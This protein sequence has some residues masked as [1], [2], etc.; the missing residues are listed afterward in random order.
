[1]DVQAGSGSHSR[2][3]VPSSSCAE[4]YS[5]IAVIVHCQLFPSPWTP[6]KVAYIF[7]RYYPLAFAPFHLWD[8][9]GDHDQHVCELYYHAVYACMIPTV[10]PFPLPIYI[11]SRFN[12]RWSQPI[13]STTY[14]TCFTRGS[15]TFILSHPDLAY[16]CVFWAEK[17]DS[18]RSF[19]YILPLCRCS[20]LG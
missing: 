10:C 3:H 17:D 19:S 1:M 18:C 13:V 20:Y 9:L 6:V 12:Y 7:C 16:I 4:R 2:K 15:F 14:S 11:S 8:L 5:L